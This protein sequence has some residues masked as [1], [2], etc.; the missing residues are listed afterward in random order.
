MKRVC[1]R[2]GILLLCVALLAACGRIPTSPDESVPQDV[3]LTSTTTSE[4]TTTT[5]VEQTTTT[6]TATTTSTTST[7]T[8]TATTTTTTTTTS[9]TLTSSYDQTSIS[10]AG[11]EDDPP[12]E[13]RQFRYAFDGQDVLFSYTGGVYEELKLL[14]C[15]EGIATAGEKVIAKVSAK[16]G[17][18]QSVYFE[19]ELADEPDAFG[20]EARQKL[21]DS[22]QDVQSDL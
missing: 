9:T 14:W 22:L 3:S 6:T 1:L 11:P 5:T 19:E 4:S 18:V 21:L 20:M 15:Y 16:K 10:T 13:K 12:Q 8:T 2:I 7:T 17:Y